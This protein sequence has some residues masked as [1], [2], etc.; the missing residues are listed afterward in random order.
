MKHIVGTCWKSTHV[1]LLNEK[2]MYI[3]TSCCIVINLRN[4]T[5]TALLHNTMCP[6]TPVSLTTIADILQLKQMQR[7][8]LM[9]TVSRILE[10]HKSGT[11]MVIAD[12][13]LVYGSKN[14][15]GSTTAETFATMPLTMLFHNDAEFNQFEHHIIKHKALVCM[16]I[17][18]N[19]DARNTVTF[20]TFEGVVWWQVASGESSTT[21]MFQ[22]TMLCSDATRAADVVSLVWFV[23]KGSN[24]YTEG[25][26]T[27]TACPMFGLQSKS[28]ICNRRRCGT[29]LPTQSRVRA[30]THTRRQRI[31]QRPTI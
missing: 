22:S 4:A 8:N 7:F 10:M 13:C 27:L 30:V 23:P 5:V 20:T 9:A 29:S 16:I 2:S 17:V 15:V 19:I 3:H 24:D 31:L 14:P 28:C 1:K 26:A 21:M 25:S 11:G 18:G 12:I 6:K